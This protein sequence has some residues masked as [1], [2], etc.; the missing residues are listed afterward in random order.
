MINTTPSLVCNKYCHLRII[1]S[2]C[3]T[4]TYTSLTST[5]V[6]YKYAWVSIN[7]NPKD[8]T[9]VD[10]LE[11]LHRNMK[12]VQFTVSS[13]CQTYKQ[14]LSSFSFFFAGGL[15]HLS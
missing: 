11:K 5:S 2:K 10:R 15:F 6:H 4:L 14:D 3:H 1:A 9:V 12:T 7:P 8:D 13:E